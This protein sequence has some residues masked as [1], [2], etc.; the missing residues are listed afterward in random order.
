[1]VVECQKQERGW[2]G[3][4]QKGKVENENEN[5]TSKDFGC[6]VWVAVCS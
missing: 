6:H 3:R 1:M 2:K 5:Q 4:E